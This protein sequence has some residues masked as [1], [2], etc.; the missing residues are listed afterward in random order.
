[1]PVSTSQIFRVFVSSTFADLVAERDALQGDL[2]RRLRALCEQHRARF[3]WVDLRWGVSPEAAQDHR[4]MT[5][6][7]DEIR[8]CRQTTPQPNFIVL[9][10]GRYGWRPL[11]A[12]V[13]VKDFERLR[14]TKAMTPHLSRLESL[15]A[16]ID[17][18]AVPAVYCLS[19]Q[20]TTS[21]TERASVRPSP[22]TSG[23]T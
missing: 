20:G 1:M 10:G 3:A 2:L 21:D 14:Q 9:L 19:P 6:C 23:L 22:P 5:I 17:R 15:Y 11:P 18:N 8:R 4:T 16:S 13:P 12:E 7:L